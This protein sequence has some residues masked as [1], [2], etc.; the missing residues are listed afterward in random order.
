MTTLDWAQRIREA[1][2]ATAAA[3]AVEEQTI[4][5]AVLLGGLSRTAAA[6]AT[7]AGSNRNRVGRI[8]GE[9]PDG[10]EPTE[11]AAVPVVYVNGTGRG[12][13][14][15]QRVE[16]AMWARGWGTVTNRDTAWHLARGG[17]PVVK[18]WYGTDLDRSVG[19]IDGRER[20]VIVAR[21]RAR[22]VETIQYDT[23]A[24]YMRTADYVRLSRDGADW[25]DHSF[26]AIRREPEL[27]HV[28]GGEHSQP[29]RFD[30]NALNAAGGAG[31]HVIDE[32]V[33]ARLV[34]AVL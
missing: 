7:G 31:A 30:P 4:R 34:A 19:A 33:L 32:Q 12:S 11:P 13:E 6:K 2:A 20:Y 17:T 9:S 10:G 29:L 24:T 1:T 23:P 5:D 8:L 18:C 21:V 22:Y 27:V 28:V 3:K 26:P 16:R 14:T 25:L 15:H